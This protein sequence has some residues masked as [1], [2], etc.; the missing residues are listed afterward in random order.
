MSLRLS[1]IIPAYK[2]ED[3]I[4]KCIRSLEDQDIP[5]TEYEIIVTND[6]S[7][8]RCKEIV[9]S[10]Q[11]EFSNIVL[12]D[13][14]NQGVSM[15]RNNAITIA[16]GKYILPIDPDDYVLPNTLGNALEQAA[17]SDLDVLFLGFE[18]FDVEGNSAWHT[19]YVA[20]ESQIHTGVEAYFASR[21]FEVRD[22]D[23]SVGMLYKK[24]LLQQYAIDYPKN[25]P[26]LE[27]GL[28]LSKVFAVAEK[29]GFNNTSFYQRTTREGSATNSKLFYSEK[30]I[31]GFIN[32]IED[33]KFFGTKNEFR[34]EQKLLI[35]HVV[36][37]FTLLPL[38]SIIGQKSI[39]NYYKFIKK[40]K[41]KNFNKITLEGLRLGYHSMASIYNKSA[42]LFYI[43]YPIITKLKIIIK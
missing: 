39:G 10:L 33:I 21:G 23:R 3:Y 16:K 15:A 18:I 32:A 20:L 28:F 24:S 42:L 43:Y 2:V 31:Q 5:K 14:E 27:D 17:K 11:K 1:I 6:G 4:E 22:P 12:V 35:N 13:Q 30:A 40:L 38:T 25:V 37:K 7:P 29:V 26:Y 34:Q 19:N 36:A 9:E 8:D 41:E